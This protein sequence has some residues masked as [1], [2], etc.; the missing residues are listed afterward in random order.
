M[1]WK[2]PEH[3]RNTYS[4]PN[5]VL[6][7]SC[8]YEGE[9]HY[10]EENERCPTEREK[11]DHFYLPPREG[12]EKESRVPEKEK[13]KGKSSREVLLESALR[14]YGDASGMGK[15]PVGFLLRLAKCSEE[16]PGR[17]LALAELAARAV[18]EGRLP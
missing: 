7:L 8:R 5:G 13:R 17:S 16:T 15:L 1:T 14:V 9:L 6:C 4:V 3:P 2:N 12:F 11:Y 10:G 18:L